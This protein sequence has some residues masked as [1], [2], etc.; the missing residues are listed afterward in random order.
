MSEE[1]LLLAAKQSLASIELQENVFYSTIVRNPAKF[2][3][4]NE[5]EPEEQGYSMEKILI[6]EEDEKVIN[7]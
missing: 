1:E 4:A 2:I 3:K 5:R 6:F 7:I